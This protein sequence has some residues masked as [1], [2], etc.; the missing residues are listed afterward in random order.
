MDKK[1][2]VTVDNNDTN[3][4]DDDDTYNYE[5]KI[6]SLSASKVSYL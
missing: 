1:A 3:S 5:N 2:F 4:N 6:L